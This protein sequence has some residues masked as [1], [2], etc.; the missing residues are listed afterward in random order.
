MLTVRD[1]FIKFFPKRLPLSGQPCFWVFLVAFCIRMAVLVRF[2]DAS[3]QMQQSGDMKFYHEWALRIAGGELTDYQA[4]YGMP[5]YAYALGLFYRLFSA[6]PFLIGLLQVA[7]EG[8]IAVLIYKMA[9][10][11]APGAVNRLVGALAALGWIFFQPAQAFSVVLMPTTWLVLGFWA[12]VFWATRPEAKEYRWFGWL[13][14]GLLVGT[15]ALMVAT[16]LLLI[17]LVVLAVVKRAGNLGGA[18]AGLALG[19]FVGTSPCWM[20]NYLVAKEPVLFSAHSGLNF[21]IG[22]NPTANGY[23]QIPPG[24]RAGQAG[25]LQDSITVAQEEAG[26][27]LTRA[28][29]S[30]HWSA[31]A[32][33]YIKNHRRQWIKLMG[34]KLR[35]FWNAFQYDDLGLIT[36]LSV[37]NVLTPGLRFGAVAA[38]ALPGMVL[39]LRASR[40]A[41]WIA[42]AVFSHL[43]ALLPVFVTER[44]R[45]AAV[46]GLLI[47]ASLGLVLLVRDLRR[48]RW[49]AVSLY[50]ATGVAAL[51]FVR[52]PSS[53]AELKAFDDYNAGFRALE[54]GKLERAQEYLDKALCQ[55]P[56]N[57]ETNFALGNLWFEKKE[58]SKAKQ[59]YRRTLE[60]N[61]RH[62]GAY[63]NLGV[64]ALEE[65]R[66]EVAERF[67]QRSLAINGSNA[68]SFYLLAKARLGIG[69][70]PGALV[71]S[72]KALSIDPDNRLFKELAAEIA[73][74]P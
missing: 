6:E 10:G 21:Y 16:I 68:K 73:K 27:Q 67:L 22:N 28:E 52:P 60:V 38:L 24:L 4:F 59:F 7:S 20:H 37:E 49:S 40:R 72:Q 54:A 57:D 74:S 70:K 64:I 9:L 69:D 50:L 13:G 11:I 47:F 31:K 55:M 71:F 33:D 62:E 30:K 53:S 3:F 35:N 29:V 15:T 63:N 17:P 26:R 46:P 58:P 45:L 18:L 8:L 48:A 51:V 41:L 34:V 36:L 25:M 23:P 43:C 5:G 61:P 1:T 39:G 14:I 12:T 32:D 2:G 42:G 44:Y 65:K 56:G 19:L 66:W